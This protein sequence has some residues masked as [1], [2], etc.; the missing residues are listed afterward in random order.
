MKFLT[1]MA[2]IGMLVSVVRVFYF[3]VLLI[4]SARKYDVDIYRR[5]FFIQWNSDGL[6]DDCVEN[7]V[8]LKRAVKYLFLFF[9]LVAFFGFMDF[10]FFKR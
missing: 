2:L 4:F 3:H 8:K 9:V 7:L 5:P 10:M 1:A 6:D